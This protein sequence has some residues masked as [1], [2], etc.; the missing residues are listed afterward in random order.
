[1]QTAERMMPQSRPSSQPSDVRDTRTAA[2]AVADHRRNQH[3][4]PE[5][6]VSLVSSVRPVRR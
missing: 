1:M 3:A 6:R 4:Q 2:D 5:R